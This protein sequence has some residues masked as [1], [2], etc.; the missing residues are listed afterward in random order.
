MN[1]LKIREAVVVEGKYD[2]IK[3]S[4][5]I[6]APILVTNGFGIFRDQ[7]QLELLRQMADRRGLL[8]LTDSDSAGFLIR[9]YLKGAID[10]KKM[11]QAYIPDIYGKE[12]RKSAPGKE[13][14]LGVEGIPMPI[15]RQ[16]L[17]QAG[18]KVQDAPLPERPITKTDF[19]ELGL[20]GGT[21]SAEKRRAVQ[22]A[23]RLPERLSANAL[24]EVLNTLTTYADL[25][26][27]CHRFFPDK[28]A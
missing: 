21:K 1:K 13:G 27:L 25:C 4:A 9:N 7:Q 15:L 3:L 24:L 2:K 6:D 18:V 14:K 8:I 10:P 23:L 17:L 22:R 28:Q 11:K 16:C 20:S 26:Q 12:K 5:L 19:Y